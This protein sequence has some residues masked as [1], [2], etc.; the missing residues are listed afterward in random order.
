MNFSNIT[1]T[2]FAFAMM[3][4]VSLTGCKE[5]EPVAPEVSMNISAPSVGTMFG[6]DDTIHVHAMVSHEEEMHG[7]E[8]FIRNTSM[9]DTVVWYVS[10]H[11]HGTEFHIEGEWVNNVQHHSDMEL[12]INVAV[13]HDGEQVSDTVAFHC[14]PM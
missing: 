4:I 14:H 12:I 1:Y 2:V 10:E 11:A 8:A 3:A 7:Y 5:E 6:K 13:T 9:G